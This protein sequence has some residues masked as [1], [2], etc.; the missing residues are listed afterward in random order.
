MKKFGVILL[1]SAAAG[2]SYFA[3]GYFNNS[4]SYTVIAP[5][6]K[7]KIA[8]TGKNLQG[9]ILDSGKKQLESAKSFVENISGQAGNAFSGLI[10]GT[11]NTLKEQLD[12]ILET[13]SSPSSSSSLALAPI[14]AKPSIVSGP[15][16][17]SSAEA[18]VCF[19]VSKGESIE[20]SIGQP[21]AGATAASYK[22]DWGDGQ[23]INGVFHAGDQ[24]V[25]VSHSYS[26][27]GTFPAAFQLTSGS[28]T[29]TASRSVCVK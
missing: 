23:G 4:A 11:K 19:V 21:F 13:T 7:N 28:T 22:I 25:V 20:Y 9:N 3:W 6:G 16:Q 8:A 26:Q 24:N 5:S 29:L 10:D 2:L 15:A 18:L 27:P 14:P 17:N 12:N 1:I